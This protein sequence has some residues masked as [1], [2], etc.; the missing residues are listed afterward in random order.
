MYTVTLTAKLGVPRSSAVT[1]TVYVSAVSRSSGTEVLM[2]PV[3][4]SITKLHRKITRYVTK[5]ETTTFIYLNKTLNKSE[6]LQ[7]FFTE[8]RTTYLFET[9][10]GSIE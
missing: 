5:R 4:A 9:G 7:H 8:L 3:E 10:D 2:V 1:V 6:L